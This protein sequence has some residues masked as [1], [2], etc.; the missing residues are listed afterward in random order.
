MHTSTCVCMCDQAHR[1]GMPRLHLCVWVAQSDLLGRHVIQSERSALAASSLCSAAHALPVVLWVCG[2]P[3]PI[4]S[5]I[6]SEKMQKAS[7]A[8]RPGGGNNLITWWWVLGP[9]KHVT[10]CP[11]RCQIAILC[12]GALNPVSRSSQGVMSICFCTAEQFLV[13]GSEVFTK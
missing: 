7:P 1:H 11:I 4:I 5:G 6:C 2:T 10:H 8:L 3:P 9:I 12:H 13:L